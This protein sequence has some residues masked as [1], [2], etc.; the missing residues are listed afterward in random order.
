MKT[1][2]RGAF[3]AALLLVGMFVGPQAAWAQNFGFPATTGFTTS[4]VC[5]HSGTPASTC[6]V[7]TDGSPFQPTVVS[8]GVL[9]LTSANLNQHGA[10]W[11]Y[12]PQQLST[13]F[14]TA[15]QFRI[16]NTNLCL[17]CSFPAD[18]M[19]LVIQNDPAGTG[20][21]GYTGNG[22]NMAYGNNDVSTASGP[23]NAITN[24]LAIE[25]DT[26]QN[27][28]FSDPNGNHIAVQSCGPNNASTLTPNSADHDYVCPDGNLAKIALQSLPAGLSLSDG[29]AHTITV[30]YLPP[31]TCTSG[32]NNLSV[33]MD[34]TLILQATLNITTQLN[35][36]SNGGAYIGFTA[37]TGSHV[38][39][40]DVLSWSFSSLPLAPITITQPLQPTQTNFNYTPTLSA[41]SDYSQSGLGSG[42]FTGVFQ[43]G[44]VQSITDNGPG[45]Q[46]YNLVQNTPFQ[47]TTCQHQD[48]GS[49]NYACVI[50]TDLCTT[51]SSST[52]SG[53]N[54]PQTGTNSPINVSNTYN[55][56]PS[57]KPIIAPGYIMGTDNALTCENQD[58]VCKNLTNIFVSISGDLATSN[59][60]TN[61]FNSTLIPILG[62]V[63]P[64]TSPTTNPPLNQGWTNASVTLTLNSTDVV[65][66]NNTGALF[67][68]PAVT[69]INYSATGANL[70]SP[71]SGTI[72]GQTGSITIPNTA[73]GATVVTFYATDAAGTIESTTT[74]NN[75]TVSSANP[76][77]T[78][79]VD[80]IP[81]T[82]S[83]TPPAP[84]WQANDVTVPCSASDNAGGSGLVGP[85]SFNLLTA[86][87]AGAETSSATIAAVTVQD[88]AGNTSAPQGPFGPFE[89]DKKPPVINGPTISPS[90]PTFGQ[91]ITASYSC[92][93]GGS[94][95]VLCGP[96]GSAN[97]PATAN[98]GTLTLT[99]PGSVG[100][101][102]I[103]INAQDAVGNQSAPS[104]LNYSVGQATPTI[105][106]T[107]PPAI[108]YGTALG[109][110]QLD[111]TASVAGAFAYSPATGTVLGAGPQTLSV[112]FTPTDTTDYTTATA[113]APL[114]VTQATPT[115]TWATPAAI[116]YG[117]ALGATQLNA[118]A[119]VPGTFA[120]NPAAPTVLTAGSH[121]L[122]V[123]FTPTDA[124]DYT[125]ATANVTLVVNQVTPTITWATPAAI[126]YGT[127]LSAAQL[128]A[129]AS[130][131]GTFLYSPAAGTVLTAGTQ[132]LSVAFTPT[133]T[134]DYANAAANVSLQVNKAGPTITW[135]TPAAITYGTALS[136][137]QLNATASVPGTFLYSPAAGTVLG[138]GSQPL[139]VSFTPTD[140]TDYSTATANVSLQV[141][142]AASTITWATPAAITYGTALS[143]AQLNAT[144]SVPGT[145]VYSPAAGTVLNAGSQPLSVSFTPTD[146]TDYSTAT[147][148]VSLQVNQAA[149]II[150]WPTPAPIPYGTALSAIQ[151]DATANVPGAF[152]YT[153]GAG[154]VLAPGNQTL[155]VSFTP[156]SLNYTSAT[157]QVM[158][159]VTQPTVSV[160]PTSINFG[161]V[162]C[163][164]TATQ[165][166]TVSNV[167]NA[168]VK[169]SGVSIQC[170]ASCDRDDFSFK[171][172][173]P[174]S[175]AA[176]KSCS[177][178]V[179]F[180]ADDA[181]STRNATLYITDNA[182]GSPQSVTLTG[183]VGKRK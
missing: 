38:E 163:D 146:S 142:K 127:A 120:Y 36:T 183:T 24:S 88:V 154:T 95:V 56:D 153:P 83:C 105:T 173:C 41:V 8:G 13:G 101:H 69:G 22:Q 180:N 35:L 150:N 86:V 65:P 58:N 130:V 122:S 79:Q 96:T 21:I 137:A 118:A 159:V 110:T 61:S 164:R 182:L 168:T 99:A 157:A 63:Q 60:H 155:S 68:L 23:G 176:G 1:V 32:C 9:R 92:T 17:F 129:T 98:T 57:Q 73:Q 12:Q 126:T 174:A 54:C 103:T 10:A 51:S 133:D 89:V 113:T 149:P 91:T 2:L 102:T 124:T 34:S 5:N 152:V 175:L 147:A 143:A 112:T 27:T 53:A 18:G 107:A 90:S 123:T 45:S 19:A 44:T 97:I 106:W 161:T 166:V 93:D 151:L 144:A 31:G 40:N 87:P 165:T 46:F 28:N 16:S 125:T 6:Q 80:T 43:Q 47:G 77:F 138:A 76:T 128:N 66:S 70:P 94:G 72:T 100:S 134:T 50:T 48:T 170:G 29:N 33:Y 140:A 135:A 132:T 141:N 104:V 42:A 117:T 169:I 156:S 109:A 74:N 71:A 116:P 85:P 14:T 179:T 15:F 148:N 59:G 25:L 75:G 114:V 26:Y 108:T 177:I 55:L 49:G 81:P 162:A 39:N 181:G 82:V 171:N 111:A 64:T 7:L 158:L 119:S 115:I 52:P 62:V 3:T 167:G 67:P 178:A 30:N 139:S 37:A 20:A 160:S 121:T 78:I 145:L 11:Y 131:P 4:D 136:V 84:V 172:Y